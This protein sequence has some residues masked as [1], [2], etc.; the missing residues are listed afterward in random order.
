MYKRVRVNVF[1]NQ[2]FMKAKSI[3]FSLAVLALSATSCSDDKDGYGNENNG[4]VQF[5]SAIVGNV[6]TRATGTTWSPADAIG[7]YMKKAGQE[8]ADANVISNVANNKYTTPGS[9]V[10]SAAKASDA[11]YLPVDGSKV[12]FIAYYPYKD[13]IDAYTYKVD[14]ATQTSQEAIDLLYSKDAVNQD[15]TNAN[16][17]LGFNHQLT[18]MVLNVKA[19]SGIASLDGLSIKISGMKTKADFALA[20]GVLTA[21]GNAGDIIV[22]TAANGTEVM[23]EAIVLPAAAVAGRTITFTLPSG[24]FKWEIPATT[25]YKS[26]TRYSYDVELKNTGAVVPNGTISD[27]TDGSSES[28]VIENGD[29]EET[30]GQGTKDSPYTVA[31]AL[32]KA[33]ESGKWIEGY[34]VGVS[35]LTKSGSFTAPFTSKT[36]ILLAATANET[37]YAKCFPVELVDGSEIQKSLNLV[38]N[39]TLLG[40]SVKVQGDIVASIFGS[41]AGLSAVTAQEG[42]VTT[43]TNP[44]ETVKFFEETFGTTA[45]AKEKAKIGVYEKYDM[46]SPVTYSDPYG[47]W[48]DLRTS[49]MFLSTYNMHVWLPAFGTD[50]AS[51]VLIQGFETGYTDMKL[52]YDIAT[53]GAAGADANVIVVKCNGTAVAVPSTALEKQNEFKTITISIP[54]NTTEIEFYSGEANTLG[55]RLDNIK[56]EGKK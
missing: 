10:F 37:D 6:Q 8:L 41:A 20:T 56:L 3:L 35:T 45:D 47:T 34:V 31:Q 54:D 48:A 39:V 38:D 18:K 13:P 33:G 51:G 25:E 26:G 12:D 24:S 1:E 43:P 53:N 23:G 46:K 17:A 42:G 15:K 50:K 40:K 21:T 4:A 16:I 11:I 55:F 5:S 19:G 44:G 9:G 28:I 29:D 30:G 36:N 27:W 14:V 2:L 49:A 22:K 32:A 52:S 7:V